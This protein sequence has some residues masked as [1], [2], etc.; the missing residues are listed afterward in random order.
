[1]Y[2]SEWVI[3]EKKSNDY[4]LEGEFTFNN[5]NYITKMVDINTFFFFFKKKLFYLKLI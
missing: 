1:M 5:N 2:S 3:G 4:W